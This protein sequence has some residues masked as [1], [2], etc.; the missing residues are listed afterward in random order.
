MANPIPTRGNHGDRQASA[1]H[2]GLYRPQDDQ[3]TQKRLD[4]V[5]LDDR[6]DILEDDL[7]DRAGNGLLPARDVRSDADDDEEQERR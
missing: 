5:G 3:L 4:D 6:G 2:K 7:R 1:R